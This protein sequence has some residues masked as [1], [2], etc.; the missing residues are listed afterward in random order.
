MHPDLLYFCRCPQIKLSG[1]F[2]DLFFGLKERL[3]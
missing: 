2:V 3:R 1:R